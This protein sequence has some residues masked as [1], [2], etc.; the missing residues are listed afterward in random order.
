MN[1]LPADN[2]NEISSLITPGKSCGGKDRSLKGQYNLY[3]MQQLYWKTKSSC[4]R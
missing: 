4:L 2:S 3:A 1:C